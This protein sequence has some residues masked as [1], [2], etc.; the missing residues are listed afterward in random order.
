M[1]DEN[2]KAISP[3][4]ENKSV[5]E[6]DRSGG[7]RSLVTQRLGF[8]LAGSRVNDA[9]FLVLAGRHEL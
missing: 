7:L 1:L 3:R 9:N 5:A 6:E 2:A 4:C 8:D